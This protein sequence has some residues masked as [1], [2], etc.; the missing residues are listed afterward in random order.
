VC[1]GIA[2]VLQRRQ[3]SVWRGLVNSGIQI[4]NC[5]IQVI[6][7]SIQ[8][9]LLVHSLPVYKASPSTHLR[10][11]APQDAGTLCIIEVSCARAL[12]SLLSLR[13][14]G[15]HEKA[16]ACRG[17]CHSQGRQDLSLI[18]A[19]LPLTILRTGIWPQL[20]C[21]A[22]SHGRG[23]FITP[24]DGHRQSGR[25]AHGPCQVCVFWCM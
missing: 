7:S 6:N 16:G 24:A 10:G 11:R 3:L 13:F 2:Q 19:P 17:G 12:L 25:T 4:I 22:G 21:A 9:H 23:P 8:T 20:Q 1:I 5:S 14:R 18:S 15:H